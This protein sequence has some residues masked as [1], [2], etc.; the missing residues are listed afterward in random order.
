VGGVKERERGGG[1]RG[2]G[3]GGRAAGGGAAG[4]MG[5]GHGLLGSVWLLCVREF[6][7]SVCEACCA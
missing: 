5:G 1:S 6:C 3:L 2:R 4:D 7:S